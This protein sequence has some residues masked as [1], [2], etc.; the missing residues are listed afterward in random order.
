MPI[1]LLAIL[2]TSCAYLPLA[3]RVAQAACTVLDASAPP[4]CVC[5]CAAKVC[6]EPGP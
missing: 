5:E 2:L 4:P 6:Q 1:L 3:V